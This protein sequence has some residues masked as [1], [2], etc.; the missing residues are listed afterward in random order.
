VGAAC[1]Y[2]GLAYCRKK[3]V[4]IM[5][6]KN[7]HL[8]A[9]ESFT[10]A[11]DTI[12]AIHKDMRLFSIT[13]G[14]FSMIDA[15][16]AVLDQIGNA[17][18]S[19]WTWT[20][21]DYE[22]QCIERLLIDKRLINATLIIDNGAQKKNG[23]IIKKWINNHGHNSVR[24]VKNHAKIARI[25]NDE[26]KILLRGSFNLNFN[27]RFE[28]FDI[29][30]GCKGFDMVQDIEKDLPILVEPTN[31]EIIAASKLNNAFTTQQLSIFSPT[32]I[33]KK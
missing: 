21:A 13:R 23:E 28:N 6:G 3:G 22:V 20:V 2:D 25:W 24:W 4:F 10:T 30:E 26:Y 7:R 9:L 32:K 5:S 17:N 33:W 29:S 31:S 16:L 8:T 14:Q 1:E 12:G 15:I 27:P 18:I 19:I 11:R